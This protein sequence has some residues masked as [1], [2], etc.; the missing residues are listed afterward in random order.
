MPSWIYVRF[1]K[2]TFIICFESFACCLTFSADCNLPFF[3]LRI[4]RVGSVFSSFFFWQIE[5]SEML[6]LC[7]D[8][9]LDVMFLFI[10]R[11]Y[12]AQQLTLSLFS[13]LSV[14][15]DGE[16]NNKVNILYISLLCPRHRKSS[17][18]YFLMSFS[19]TFFLSPWTLQIAFYLIKICIYHRQS[20]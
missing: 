10:W 2:F 20:T 4:L 5:R 3:R 16:V 7:C 18:I 12:R 14:P 6:K 15:H 11:I 1:M 13:W 19:T 9:K 8:A 17:K